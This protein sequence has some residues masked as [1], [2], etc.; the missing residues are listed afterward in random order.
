MASQSRRQTVELTLSPRNFPS[1]EH[2]RL[3][4][5]VT[6]RTARLVLPVKNP[7]L[8]W[9]WDHGKPNLYTLDVKLRD[10]TGAVVDG[11]SLAVGI[12]EIERIG[13]TFYLNRRRLFIRG[14]NYYYHLYLS[15]M[16]R[17]AYERDLG[18]MLQMN[19]NLIRLHC[20]F[21][22]PAFY[23]VADE[24]GLLVWQDYL[25]AWYPEDRAFSLRAAALYDPLI[26]YVRNHACIA[27]WT[28]C[29]EESL[30]NYRD[31]TKH[32]AP[33]PGAARSPAAR[34]RPLHG[35]VRGRP[36]LSRLVRR[37]HLGIHPN[38]RAVCVGV[39]GNL[40]PQLRDRHSSTYRT[41]GPSGSTPTNGSFAGCKFP[42]PCGRGATRAT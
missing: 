30:E 22:N 40:L 8:W 6:G 3:R 19:V 24:L 39:G 12:R 32:L 36:C 11:R 4:A 9:T 17:A 2:L 26:K 42:K 21:D 20:H 23:D 25:E 29:D 37:Q 27:S 33:R 28:T 38:D 16:N 34:D 15:E 41:P 14:T 1:N 31:L 35:P 10:Q 5:V 7:Q 13:W 18:L